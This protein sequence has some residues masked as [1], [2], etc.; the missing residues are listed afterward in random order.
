MGIPY[1]PRWHMALKNDEQARRGHARL[2]SDPG[3]PGKA[4]ESGGLGAGNLEQ[5]VFVCSGFKWRRALM[6]NE[7]PWCRFPQVPCL[8]NTLAWLL[9]RPWN[10]TCRW[11]NSVRQPAVAFIPP[12]RYLSFLCS[13]RT[14]GVE[15]N[16]FAVNSLRRCWSFSSV[17][18]SQFCL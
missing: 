10:E 7:H 14:V 6:K 3:S 13:C 15:S 1:S 5:R 9:C 8:S 11:W 16:R 4:G 18:E 2:L 12:V 17:P